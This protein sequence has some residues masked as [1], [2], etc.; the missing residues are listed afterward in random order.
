MKIQVNNKIYEDSV[1]KTHD[2]RGNAVMTITT[3]ES[4][5]E[6]AQTFDAPNSL[7]ITYNDDDIET[8]RWYIHQLISIYENYESKLKELPREIVVS[9]RASTLTASTEENIFSQIEENTEAILELGSLIA[10]VTDI[11]HKITMLEED[12]NAIPTN[13]NERFAALESVY[14]TLADRIAVLENDRG[15]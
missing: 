11:D 12:L 7:I 1:W 8:G 10:D 2:E 6:V 4:I 9:I 3:E 15:G 13:I 5:G 14:N